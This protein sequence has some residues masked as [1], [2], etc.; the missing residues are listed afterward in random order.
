[1]VSPVCLMGASSP[2]SLDTQ[3]VGGEGRFLPA[4][5][6]FWPWWAFSCVLI[7]EIQGVTTKASGSS[8]GA[9]LW[10]SSSEGTKRQ[11][12]KERKDRNLVRSGEVQAGLEGACVFSEGSLEKAGQSRQSGAGRQGAGETL[13]VLSCG[14]QHGA[15]GQGVTALVWSTL[16]EPLGHCQLACDF[17]DTH[18]LLPLRAIPVRGHA[19]GTLWSCSCMGSVPRQKERKSQM[20]QA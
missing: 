19:L 5:G 17:R 20:G 10:R 13:L 1:M 7:L 9:I 18:G 2:R 14:R 15:R 4:Y 11:R 6:A 8:S 3:P 12:W 16:R